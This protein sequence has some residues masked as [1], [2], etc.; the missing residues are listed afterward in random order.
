MIN[1]SKAC[2]P[3]AP[4]CAILLKNIILT[5]SKLSNMGAMHLREDWLT[6]DGKLSGMPPE[7]KIKGVGNL[8][9]VTV[10]EIDGMLHAKV[11]NYEVVLDPG[12]PKGSSCS[13]PDF[14]HN[15]K[16]KHELCKHIYALAGALGAVRTR[17]S[18]V[19]P[20]VRAGK[21]NEE[22]YATPKSSLTKADGTADRRFTAGEKKGVAREG[23]GRPPSLAPR[24]TTKV[25]EFPGMLPELCPMHL[26]GA[27]GER[28]TQC[29][30]HRELLR[31]GAFACGSVTQGQAMDIREAV[32]RFRLLERPD[33]ALAALKWCALRE[34]GEHKVFM[35]L[36][37]AVGRVCRREL[38][39]WFVELDRKNR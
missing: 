1:D 33:W 8:S 18:P 29:N 24:L 34:P 27:T 31:T 37:D 13:C 10:R 12:S 9:G 17:P 7:G 25:P 36:A 5:C 28:T 26:L 6:L 39:K 16:R 21:K 32:V 15:R 35:E 4:L 19:G 22:K 38:R 3:I 2:Q 23:A 20:A 11:R 14:S 30:Q